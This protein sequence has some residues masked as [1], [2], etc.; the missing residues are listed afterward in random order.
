MSRPHRDAE[1]GRTRLE[2]R[3]RRHGLG[4]PPGEYGGAHGRLEPARRVRH[5]GPRPRSA[6]RH[7]P[8]RSAVPPPTK[9]GAAFLCRIFEKC[10]RL[11]Q[12]LQDYVRKF[13][14]EGLEINSDYFRLSLIHWLT[15]SK[16]KEFIKNHL[17]QSIQ[18][19]KLPKPR[20]KAKKCKNII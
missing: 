8:D 11:S 2:N 15:A 6:R 16:I 4:S 1:H 13:W 5:V 3:H 20:L 7:A 17:D 19:Q 10:L 14:R 9:W 12:V 18:I